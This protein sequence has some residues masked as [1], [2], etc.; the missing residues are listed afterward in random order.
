M[1]NHSF[2]PINLTLSF[3]R[4]PLLLQSFAILLLA[5]RLSQR[6]VQ[7]L[8]GFSKS[9]SQNRKKIVFVS[10]LSFSGGNVT[11]RGVFALF[12][13]S[14]PDPGRR[15]NGPLFGLKVQLKTRSKSAS[16]EPLIDFL[17]YREQKLWLIN[18]KLTNILLP[19]KPLWGAFLPRR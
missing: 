2:G 4:I 10:G 13:P 7:T 14:L 19:Q 18:Q 5:R 8:Y 17:A 3:P 6:A 11:S 15:P 1:E 12:W 9:C 16:I